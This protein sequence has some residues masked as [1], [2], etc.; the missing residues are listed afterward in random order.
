MKNRSKS[1]AELWEAHLSAGVLLG[2][3]GAVAGAVAGGK[4]TESTVII[5][6]KNGNKALAKVNSPMMEVI[7]AHLFDEQ[8]AQERGKPTPFAQQNK[9]KPSKAKKLLVLFVCLVVAGAWLNSRHPE[10]IAPQNTNS[11][12]RA[13]N[14]SPDCEK[15]KQSKTGSKPIPSGALGTKSADKG[16]RIQLY[17]DAERH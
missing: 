14:L 2:G 7:R 3:I 6:F 15:L 16:P 12:N 4:T 5:E 11:T 13:K 17:M 9:K 8:L 1:S 10:G